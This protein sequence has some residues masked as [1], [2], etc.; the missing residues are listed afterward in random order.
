MRSAACDYSGALDG[1][2]AGIAIVDK[3]VDSRR[4]TDWSGIRSHMSYL[5]AAI[6]SRES[7]PLSAERPW[8]L[9]YRVIVHPGRWDA[10]ALD[11]ASAAF[12]ADHSAA[13]TS[14]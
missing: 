5:N 12:N 10:A 9:E 14:R 8:R 7:Y 3:R 2:T 13:A 6:L 4:P 1:K 11:A